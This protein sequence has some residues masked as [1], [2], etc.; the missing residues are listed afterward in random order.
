MCAINDPETLKRMRNHTTRIHAWKVLSW[1][2][3]YLTPVSTVVGIDY[4]PGWN[5]AH[6]YE[7]LTP[8]LCL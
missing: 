8:R 7:E 1:A 3:G 5:H 4:F 2:K 6:Y